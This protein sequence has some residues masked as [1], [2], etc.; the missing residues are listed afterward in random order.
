MDEFKKDE[1][2]NQGYFPEETVHEDEYFYHDEL[3]FVWDKAKNE[4]NIRDHGVDLG[5]PHW[6]LMIPML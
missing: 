3:R 6:C 4:V 5:L 2:L 1:D